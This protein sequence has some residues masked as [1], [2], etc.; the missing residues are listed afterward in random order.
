[1]LGPVE[2]VPI[3]LV[4]VIACFCPDADAAEAIFETRPVTPRER[5]HNTHCSVRA[6][7]LGEDVRETGELLQL[8][9]GQGMRQAAHRVGD[10]G[11]H[12]RQQRERG[13]GDRRQRAAAVLR[14]TRPLCEALP[15]QAVEHA[16]HVRGPAVD[17]SLGNFPT[18][19]SGGIGIA[20][21]PQH[22]ILIRRDAVTLADL[23]QRLVQMI[24]RPHHA[25]G[26]VF[27]RADESSLFHMFANGHTAKSVPNTLCQD[28]RIV[29]EQFHVPN[30]LLRS[31]EKTPGVESRRHCRDIALPVEFDRRQPTI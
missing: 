1:M 31:P 14:I 10:L 22:A 26:R 11:I 18:R 20:Q 16:R 25:Q 9:T 19:A 6:I 27:G 8:R 4:D 15:Y 5:V 29:A 13:L 23:R 24:C 2:A 7:L 30:T 17:T 3:E 21:D 28:R 12:P